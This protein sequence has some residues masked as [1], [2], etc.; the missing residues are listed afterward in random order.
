M[1][2]VV[3]G[4]GFKSHVAVGGSLSTGSETTMGVN[5]TVYKFGRFGECMYP[6]FGA[7]DMF[8]CFQALDMVT[9]SIKLILEVGGSLIG[10]RERWP[11]FLKLSTISQGLFENVSAAE[12]IPKA[13]RWCVKHIPVCESELQGCMF[14]R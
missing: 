3:A 2:S 13:S 10:D 6:F 1:R 12:K 11:T 5:M 7:W 14:I 9:L 4:M 8:I